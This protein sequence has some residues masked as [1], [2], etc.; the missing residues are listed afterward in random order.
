M[1]KIVTIKVGLLGLYTATIG[2]TN[3]LDS[4]TVLRDGKRYERVNNVRVNLILSGVKSVSTFT[5]F[6]QESETCCN[7]AFFL[8]TVMAVNLL[9]FELSL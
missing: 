6:C 3:S 5:L 8:V 9:N 1:T 2:Y 4:N 7:F